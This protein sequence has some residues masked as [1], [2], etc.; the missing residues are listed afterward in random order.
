MQYVELALY[1]TRH[2][3]VI[4]IIHLLSHLIQGRRQSGIK[5]TKHRNYEYKLNKT[6]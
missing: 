4:M 3:P 6:E 2:L 1:D 5:A